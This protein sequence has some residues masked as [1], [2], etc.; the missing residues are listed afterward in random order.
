MVCIWSGY[1]GT[2]LVHLPTDKAQI[3]MSSNEETFLEAFVEQFT[4]SQFTYQLRRTLDLLRDL[5]AT[6]HADWHEAQE[7][8]HEFLAHVEQKIRQTLQVVRIDD[9]DEEGGEPPE[10]KRPRYGVRVI[11]SDGAVSTEE[12]PFIPTTEELLEYVLQG[13]QKPI[14]QRIL[15]LQQACWQK[16]EEKV[17]VAQQAYELVEAQVQRLDQDVQSMEQLLQV[18]IS[19]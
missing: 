13:D 8:S 3:M 10:R 4:S 14:Y 2:V 19:C 15:A 18:R 12:P 16:V 11:Q 5:D 9:N 17:H 7:Q 1:S 6:V